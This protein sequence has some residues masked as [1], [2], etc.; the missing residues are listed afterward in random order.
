M[1]VVNEVIDY[2][3]P[4]IVS[5]GNTAYD[6]GHM[7][8]FFLLPTWQRHAA[9]VVDVDRNDRYILKQASLCYFFLAF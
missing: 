6:F 4:C 7:L 1:C 8:H 3:S 9:T 2:L 5:A